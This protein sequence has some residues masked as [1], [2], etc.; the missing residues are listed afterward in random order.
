MFFLRICQKER[1][2]RK[3]LTNTFNWGLRIITLTFV[4]FLS[5]CAVQLTNINY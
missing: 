1:K 2:D 5:N 3:I 4:N